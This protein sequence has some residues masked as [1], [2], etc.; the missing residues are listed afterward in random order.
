MSKQKKS[1]IEVGQSIWINRKSW[2]GME[3]NLSEYK[4]AEVNTSSVY[5]K[6]EED[7]HVLRLKKS[8][9]EHRDGHL[10]N[11]QGY[12]SPDDYWNPIKEREKKNE[13]IKEI[14]ELLIC[15][16]AEELEMIKN[17]IEQGDK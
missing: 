12:L 7:K 17:Y 9:L 8:T 6:K 1:K 11:Y 15:K 13:L 2:M 3:N 16:S 5:V 10:Y 4:V 14:N